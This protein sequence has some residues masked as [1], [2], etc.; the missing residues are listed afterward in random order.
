MIDRM[1]EYR[2]KP[3]E[4]Y[5]GKRPFFVKYAEQ[6]GEFIKEH[7]LLSLE[8]EILSPAMKLSKMQKSDITPQ[9][10]A[11]VD[12]G[13]AGGKRFAHFHYRGEIYKLDQRQWLAFTSKVK[14]DLVNKL[15]MANAISIEQIQDLSD[16]IDAIG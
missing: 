1:M 4:I 11:F 5:G 6:I 10:M 2:L 9:M 13:S 14:T 8:H 15:Q 16:A 3:W 12:P 7:K